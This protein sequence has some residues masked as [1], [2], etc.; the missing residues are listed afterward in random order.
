MGYSKI[1]WINETPIRQKLKSDFPHLIDI[2]NFNI[3]ENVENDFK[4]FVERL[5]RM[6]YD[7]CL[8]GFGKSFS[9]EFAGVENCFNCSGEFHNSDEKRYIW[10]ESKLYKEIPIEVKEDENISNDGSERNSRYSIFWVYLDSVES[11]SYSGDKPYFH[12]GKSLLSLFFTNKKNVSIS[13]YGGGNDINKASVVQHGETKIFSWKYNSLDVSPYIKKNISPHNKKINWKSIFEIFYRLK[14]KYILSHPN[15]NVGWQVLKQAMNPMKTFNYLQNEVHSFQMLIDLNKDWKDLEQ[16]RSV[17]EKLSTTGF[18]K[19]APAESVYQTA[20]QISIFRIQELKDIDGTQRYFFRGQRN[21]KWSL[22][23]GIFRGLDIQNTDNSKVEFNE[24]LDS[25]KKAYSF[26]HEKKVADNEFDRLA[27]IQH[28]S[29]ELGVKTWLLDVTDSPFVALFFASANGE[30]NHIG[31][32][33]YVGKKE[34]Y[35]FSKGDEKHIGKIRYSSPTG[36]KRIENQSAY[37]IEGINPEIYDLIAPKR[38]FFKQVEGVIFENETV[39]ESKIYPKKDP[40]LD[41]I[42]DFN[43]DKIE[44]SYKKIKFK[45]EPSF[46][47][48]K[49]PDKELLLSIV[50][51]WIKQRKLSKNQKKAIKFICNLQSKLITRKFDFPYYIKSLHHLKRGVNFIILKECFH[52]AFLDEII[53]NQYSSHLENEFQRELLMKYINEI[54]KENQA[55]Q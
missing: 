21:S 5:G 16:L 20:I 47:S 52:D 11:L 18:S 8:G 1:V 26:I 41:L 2:E 50:K 35:S 49:K 45:F 29:Y 30:K 38:F 17:H 34:W 33:D 10:K 46:K 51:P 22:T 14:T 19:E 4:L 39:N 44:D 7:I 13:K 43:I 36:I 48:L 32:I 6:L 3:V 37:F 55:Q 24:R 23:S 25:L 31:I 42:M 27:V 28:Y 12:I 40:V 15:K 9:I 53:E 54:G